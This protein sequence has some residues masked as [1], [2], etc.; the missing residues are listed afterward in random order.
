[1]IEGRI[2]YGVR[3]SS[4]LFSSGIVMNEI[5]TRYLHATSGWLQA[6][7]KYTSA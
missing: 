2:P 1:M 5:R 7:E 3:P 6:Q 4:V